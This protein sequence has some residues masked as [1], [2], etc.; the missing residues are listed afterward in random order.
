MG[1]TESFRLMN[2][3]AV[4]DT[5]SDFVDAL[6]RS[7]AVATARGITVEV[8]DADDFILAVSLASANAHAGQLMPRAVRHNAR[9]ALEHHSAPTAICPVTQAGHE[10]REELPRFRQ[11]FRCAKCAALGNAKATVTY[12]L[13]CWSC[14]APATI[15]RKRNVPKYRWSCEKHV[16]L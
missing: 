3:D 12:V 8:R 16:E 4:L 14:R 11:I 15:E 10:W 7:R 5:L 1:V 6:R 9:V 13:R 2:G